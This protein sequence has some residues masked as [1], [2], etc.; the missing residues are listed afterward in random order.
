M[1]LRQLKYFVKVAQTLNFSEAARILYITQGTLSQQIIQLENEMGSKLFERSSHSVVLTEAGEELLPLAV[2]TIEASEVCSDKMRDLRGALTGKLRLGTTHS[3]CPLMTETVKFFL[4]QNP[5][6]DIKIFVETA[7]ELLDMVRDKQ[8]DLAL[9]FKP[10]MQYDEIESEPLFSSSL[11][12]VMRSGH[13]LSDKKSLSLGDIESQ[14]V[15]LPGGPLQARRIFDRYLG[16]DTRRLNVRLEV[17]DPDLIMDI[18]Q[19][20]DMVSIMSTLASYYRTGLSA[21]P[22]DNASYKM[23]G[24]VHRLKEGY[25][26]RSAEVFLEMLRESA[27]ME[28]LMKN[29]QL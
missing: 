23:T 1:E 11:S 20:T 10:I 7:S 18:V 19:G 16:I 15:V 4:K 3:F 8:L 22:L 5:G 27:Q 14:G 25:R 9:A 29:L 6:V 17:N 28:R 13:P 26:R 12:V 2:K 21:I 24:C